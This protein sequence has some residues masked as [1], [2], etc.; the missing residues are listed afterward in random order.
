[1]IA[2]TNTALEHAVSAGRFRGD[3]YYRLNVFRIELPPL[4]NRAEDVVPIAEHFLHELAAR[5]GV[6]AKTLH[7]S[8]CHLLR[9]HTWPGNAREV[10]NVVERASILAQTDVILPEHLKL[11]H[12]ELVSFGDAQ[13]I[14]GMIAIPTRG[15][16]LQEVEHETIRH[17]M[18]LTAG[19]VSAAAR[20]LGI[21]R[22]TLNRKIREID[23][24]RRSLLASS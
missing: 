11:Q 6:R 10:R 18:I 14:A 16:T 22:P 20:L 23:V 2:G 9:K 21:S 24:T 19:N 17:T 5:A 7:P 12:R 15:K 8:A 1:V 3:L 4:R 13:T